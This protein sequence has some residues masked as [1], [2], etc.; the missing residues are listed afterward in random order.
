MRELHQLN[1][2]LKAGTVTAETNEGRM[3]H[4]LDS[5]E[6]FSLVSQAWVRCGW[7]AKHVYSFAWLGRP[8]IQ[9]PDD[10]IRIQ[11]LIFQLKP[12]LII[13]TG[14]AHGGSLIF[15]ATLC[16]AMEKGRVIGIDI[17][18]RP[19]NRK[20]IEEHF[21]FPY[22]KLIEGSSTAP[23]IVSQVKSQVKPGETVLIL[24]DSCHTKEHVLAELEAYA[25][26]V[27]K[28]SYIVAT[29]G[30]M[31]WLGNAPR[32]QADWNWNNPAAAA[33]EFLRTHP[34]FKMEEPAWPF[35]EGAVKERVTYWPDA[36][37]KRVS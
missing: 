23:E 8:I 31:G 29:D 18:I 33:H 2:D 25:P 36:Y 17:E 37:L 26:M 1:I 24:L 12:D 15:Y 11:E 5:A 27:S 13:E 7:D 14:V 30:I 34:E 21:L 19:H 22:I 3:E 28:G 4:R 6:G 35:N 16:K 20:A 32:T 10:M 9:L